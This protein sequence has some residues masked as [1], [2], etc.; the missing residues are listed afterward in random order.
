[1]AA[2]LQDRG[3]G[4]F[5]IEGDLDFQ[6]V[7]A[8]WQQARR[9]FRQQPALRIDLAGV[10]RSDSSGVALLVDWLRQARERGQDLQ[11]VNIP[12]QMQAI[13]QAAGLDGLLPS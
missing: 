12:A 10:N 4:E 7:A 8:L 6:S 3:G 9:S 2:T 11:F 13:V 5:A 1:M